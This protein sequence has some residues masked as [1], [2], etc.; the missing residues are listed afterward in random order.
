MLKKL[1]Q[2]LG[3]M[4]NKQLQQLKFRNAFMEAFR[5][6]YSYISITNDLKVLEKW[7]KER[8]IKEINKNNLFLFQ[9]YVLANGLN[10]DIQL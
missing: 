10:D 4:S 5:K 3:I 1:P 7:I 6:E 9:D 2:S 8:D